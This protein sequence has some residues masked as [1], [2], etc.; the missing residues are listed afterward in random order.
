[1]EPKSLRLWKAR[2]GAQKFYFD[3]FDLMKQSY[4][5]WYISKCR[6]ISFVSPSPLQAGGAGATPPGI[7]WAKRPTGSHRVSHRPND[8]LREVTINV[9][10]K[11]GTILEKY[12]DNHFIA[13]PVEE[14]LGRKEF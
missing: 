8:T 7:V 12:A 10:P 3:L 1:M 14:I 11:S 5:I 4:G 2:Y 13:P 6:W 9:D